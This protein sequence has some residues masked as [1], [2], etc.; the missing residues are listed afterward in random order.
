MVCKF[1]DHMPFYRQIQ[2]FKRDYNWEV[3]D[4]TINEWFVACCTLMHPLYEKL[5]DKV[6]R[7]EYL[8]VDESPIKVLDRDNPN[9]IHKGYQWVYYSPGNKQV[10]FSYRKGRGENGPKEMLSEYQGIL[11][12][13]GYK[14][15]DMIGSKSGIQLAGCMAHVRRKYVDAVKNDKARSEFAL[16]IM[17]QIYAHER[18]CTGMNPSDRKDYRGQHTAP[19]LIE[20]HEWLERQIPSTTPKSKSGKAISYALKQWVKFEAFLEDGRIEIDNNLIENKI[21]PLALGRK[22]YLF[23][24]S[25]NAAERNAMMYSFMGT[26]HAHGID[27]YNWMVNVLNKIQDTKLSELDSLL[28]GAD[29]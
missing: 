6:L 11:Q 7:S 2:R 16:G 18:N 27:P 15:Y 17:Q 5:K 1:I 9:G 23:A 10:L 26:C 3:S 12:C 8:Q 14:V 21:R 13:D 24:G 22:N 29:M 19:L 28:P 4:S 20:L 25:H